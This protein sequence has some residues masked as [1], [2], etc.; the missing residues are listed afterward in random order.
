L[1]GHV[2]D[3]EQ[4]IPFDKLPE[5]FAESLER[6]PARPAQPRPA[7]TVVLMREGR[8]TLEILLMRR[9]RKAGFVPG[10]YVFPGGRVDAEDAA[11]R[12]LD[13]MDGVSSDTAARR[14]ALHDATP[15]AVAYY[16]SAMREAFEETGLLPGTDAA[17]PPAASDSSVEAIRDDLMSHRI[18]FLDALD[19]LD[20]R[21]H[22][23]AL[24]YVAHWITPLVE[25]RRYDTRFFAAEVAPG[26]EV[27]V[28]PR[29]MVDAIW[30]TPRAA[31]ERHREGSL[32]MV[33]PTLVTIRDLAIFAHP[34]EVLAHY[35]ERE[36][37]A[38][39]P[40]L[41]KTPTG[42]GLQIDEADRHGS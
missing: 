28:D 27:V 41:V 22:G 15:P 9:S 13:R 19:R 18:S 35:R 32:P 23:H 38:I 11:P 17:P 25:P 36:I 5:G 29:E 40:R 2:S 34:G 4:I 14:L 42:V 24:E 10:A 1:R 6:T 16:V 12:L 33:F 31:L 26:S 21:L 37:P 7:A 30:L 20:T 8:E 39:L 3:P